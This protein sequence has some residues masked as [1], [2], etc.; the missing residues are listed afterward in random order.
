MR[1]HDTN[2]G[3]VRLGEAGKL[4]RHEGFVVI[5]ESR[6]V[7]R[8]EIAAEVIP[9]DRPVAQGRSTSIMIN[10]KWHGRVR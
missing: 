3:L 5:L 4:D 2:N 1:E 10:D 8:R 9:N 6:E 7:D